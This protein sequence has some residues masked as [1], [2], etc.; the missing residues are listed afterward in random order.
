MW[1]Y[2]HCFT[3]TSVTDSEN[4]IRKGHRNLECQQNDNF[5]RSVGETSIKQEKLWKRSNSTKHYIHFLTFR[6]HQQQIF[7]L[8][9][10]YKCRRFRKPNHKRAPELGIPTEWQHSKGDRQNVNQTRKTE[11][12]IKWTKCYRHN[13]FHNFPES[14]AKHFLC[15]ATPI[16]IQC[17]VNCIPLSPCYVPFFLDPKFLFEKLCKMLLI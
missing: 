17:P 16:V 3:S 4:Q 11:K 14:S 13:H 9:H 7:M 6:N 12:T 8:F 5:P 10:T 1:L 2:K 15:F